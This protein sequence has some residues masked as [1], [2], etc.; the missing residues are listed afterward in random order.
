MKKINKAKILVAV[1]GLFLGLQ[2]AGFYVKNTEP[3]KKPSGPTIQETEK[4]SNDVAVNDK[5][6][7]DKVNK[8]DENKDVVKTEDEAPKED[9]KS[10]TPKDTSKETPKELSEAKV[11]YINVGQGDAQLIEVNG[12]AIL[13]DAGTAGNGDSI[14]NLLKSKGITKIDYM[15]GTH[16]HAD[17]IGGLP[18]ILNAFPVDNIVIPQ[19]ADKHVPTTKIYNDLLTA[20]TNQPNINVIRPAYGKVLY[21]KNGTQ[22]KILSNED[23]GVRT[24]NLN[25]YSVALM[26]THGDTR[27]LFTGDA[28]QEQETHILANAGNLKANVFAAGHHGSKTSNSKA[29]VSAV[30]PEIVVISSKDGNKYGHPNK[31]ALDIFASVGAKVYK[32]T[33]LGNVVI[34]SN[35]IKVTVK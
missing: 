17:H 27:F 6:S 26:F 2:I 13:I 9:K 21:D 1:V 29:F 10:E 33:D 5:D 30:N 15:I 24:G 3:T 20:I 23:I 18:K 4:D 32:T 25:N 22:L 12:M 35:G 19:V 7:K 8:K 31:E 34:T 28:E 16:P 14:I 11:T